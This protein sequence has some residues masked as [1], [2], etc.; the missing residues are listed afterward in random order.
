VTLDSVS[1]EMGYSSEAPEPTLAERRHHGAQIEKKLKG[2][3]E[4][5]GAPAI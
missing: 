5:A 1:I 2:E 4:A 3:K